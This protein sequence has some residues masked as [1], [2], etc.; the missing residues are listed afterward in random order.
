MPDAQQAAAPRQEQLRKEHREGLAPM[1]RE[2]EQLGLYAVLCPG[3]TSRRFRRVLCRRTASRSPGER[4]VALLHLRRARRRDK[5][6]LDITWLKD[7]SL[8]DV[9]N[10]PSPDVIAREIVEDL[11]AA[12]AEF[13]AVAA[14]LE[15]QLVDDAR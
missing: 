3:G 11:T 13:E 9:D 14:T 7:S 2:A 4:A 1:A 15:E 12:L 6:N 10:L 8:E 5:A